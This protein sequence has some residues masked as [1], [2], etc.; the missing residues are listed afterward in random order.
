MKS[1]FTVLF[2]SALLLGCASCADYPHH[3]PSLTDS[4]NHPSGPGSY[5]GIESP[6][7]NNTP[8][9]PTESAH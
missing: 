4:D 5:G 7:N 2:L 9:P 8:T 1:A 6:T 3:E